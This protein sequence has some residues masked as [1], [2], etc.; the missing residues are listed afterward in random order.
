MDGHN[1]AQQGTIKQSKAQLFTGIG[2][3]V[4]LGTSIGLIAMSH[5]PTKLIMSMIT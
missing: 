1:Y 3:L 5:N 2:H 4:N